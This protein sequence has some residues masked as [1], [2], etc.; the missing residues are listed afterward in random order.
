MSNFLD[1]C[2]NCMAEQRIQDV[3]KRE[4]IV[5]RGEKYEVTGTIGRCRGCG[6]EFFEV[7]RHVDP[8]ACA[9]TLYRKKHHL[10]GPDEIRRFREEYDLTQLELAALLGWGAVTLSRYENGALQDEAHDR[11]LRMA[12][13]PEGL[14]VLIDRSPSALPHEKVR[15]IM[16]RLHAC[17]CR[18]RVADWNP[19]WKLFV[20]PETANKSVAWCSGN[21]EPIPFEKSD[22]SLLAA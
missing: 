21:G 8:L 15:S 1:F 4:T 19:I 12:R 14:Q 2:P 9:Y 3:E 6:N 17:W 10:L 16:K 7:G 20:R 13:T 11:A 5:V 18:E 22:R